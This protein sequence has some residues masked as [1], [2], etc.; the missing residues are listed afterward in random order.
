M[1]LYTQIHEQPVGTEEAH[2]MAERLLKDE[3]CNFASLRLMK[4]THTLHLAILNGCVWGER[5]GEFI[6]MSGVD[7]YN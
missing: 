2:P 6:H 3:V 4:T 5:P 7:I 1:C